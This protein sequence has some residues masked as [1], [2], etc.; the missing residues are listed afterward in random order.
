LLLITG[1]GDITLPCKLTKDFLNT[2]LRKQIFRK[3]IRCDDRVIFW[4]AENLSRITD[5][6][7]PMPLGH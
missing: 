2:A 7:A 4:Y 3:K 1:A 5:K 6:M